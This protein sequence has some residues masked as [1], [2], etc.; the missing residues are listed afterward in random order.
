MKSCSPALAQRE[1]CKYLSPSIYL[2]IKHGWKI[3]EQFLFAAL[4]LKVEMDTEVDQERQSSGQES[5]VA[6]GRTTTNRMGD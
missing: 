2:L 4:K 1:I 5:R 6:G 3:S